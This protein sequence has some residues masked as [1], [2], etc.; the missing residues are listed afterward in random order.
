MP[1]ESRIAQARSRTDYQQPRTS[2]SHHTPQNEQATTAVGAEGERGFQCPR[3]RRATYA[4]GWKSRH[5]TSEGADTNDSDARPPNITAP[6][7]TDIKTH[8]YIYI[9]PASSLHR[10]RSRATRTVSSAELEGGEDD[11]GE[12]EDGHDGRLVAEGEAVDD[13]GGRPGLARHGHLTDVR[14]VPRENSTTTERGNVKF[15][16]GVCM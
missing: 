14:L 10:S 11:G 9:R 1:D 13:V 3:V 2:R 7:K 5:G 12:N 4:G 16:Q 6:L 15:W 8:T